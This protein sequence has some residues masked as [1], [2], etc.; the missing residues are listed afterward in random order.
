MA[1]IKKHS[2]KKKVWLIVLALVLIAAGVYWYYATEKYGDTSKVKSDYT[3]NALDFI[4]EF[5]VND[6]A[7]NK[8]YRERIVTING[9]IS[10]LESPDTSTMNV[11]F[12]DSTGAYII[13][14]F[15]E[16]HLQ[17]AKKLK[18]GD[19]ISIKGSCSGVAYS[20]VLEVPYISF[21]RAALNN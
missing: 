21:K 15:Q 11:K 19:S 16:Q 17:E 8:K 13:F 3:V 4:H 7:A 6:S 12:I 5:Q 2:R 18:E 10:Q 1:V 14:A 20:S 9:R